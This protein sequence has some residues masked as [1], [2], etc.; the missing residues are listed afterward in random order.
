MVSNI[1]RDKFHIYLEYDYFSYFESCKTTGSTESECYTYILDVYNTF[2][3][4]SMFMIKVHSISG[5][6]NRKLENMTKK[7]TISS[8][9]SG[10]PSVVVN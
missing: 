4:L 5:Y 10:H 8:K 7:Y 3:A 6:E 1:R 9:V 2:T